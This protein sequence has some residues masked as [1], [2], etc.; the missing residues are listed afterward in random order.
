VH[1]WLMKSEPHV[2]SIDDL[3]HSPKKTAGWEGVRNYQARNMLRDD[4]KKGDLVFF[5]HSSCTPPGIV[6]TAE[7]VRE[8]YPDESAFDPRS[9][10]Y[11]PKSSPDNPRWFQVDIKF[12]QKFEEPFTIS[13]LR[14][15]P[16]LSEMIVLRKGNRLSITP[17]AK[18]E[19]DF[20]LKLVG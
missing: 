3:I 8:G 14:T 4:M 18:K 5:Y 2:F 11:D 13:E 16:Q 1:Y 15:H 12:L 9:A 19:W 17:V 7:I 10:Y 20:I 6:G